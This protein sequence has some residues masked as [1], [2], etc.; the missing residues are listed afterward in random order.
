[1][2]YKDVSIVGLRIA[3]P[4]EYAFFSVTEPS[5]FATRT[6]TN[7]KAAQADVPGYAGRLTQDEA[8]E[9][10]KIFT[11]RVK[12]FQHRWGFLIADAIKE[13]VYFH[14]SN[15]EDEILAEK[16]EQLI[17]YKYDSYSKDDTD[18]V[19]VE[20]RIGKAKPGAAKPFQ[21]IN[22]KMAPHSQRG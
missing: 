1:K 4:D 13:N 5:A 15:V 16:L 6:Q 12:I 2:E 18:V 19:D 20:F 21:A 7:G 10:A 14:I 3:S 8:F 11:G 9:S 17:E 22:I